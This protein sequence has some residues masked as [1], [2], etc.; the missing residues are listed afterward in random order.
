MLL[1]VPWYFWNESLWV[2][3][4]VN[5]NL[6]FCCT[7][8]AAF[9]VNS[10]A[11]LYGNELGRFYAFLSNLQQVFHVQCLFVE[12]GNK[13][14]DRNINPVESLPVALAAFGEGWHNYHHVFPWDYK[15]SEFGDYKFNISTG[16]IDFFAK[17]GWA[18]D[19]KLKKKIIFLSILQT[20]QN[21]VNFSVCRQIRFTRNGCSA[22]GQ[23]WRWNASIAATATPSSSSQRFRMGIRRS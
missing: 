11:H 13:P 12:L 16:F 23:I 17:L 2:S 14:Y 22:C 20:V 19:R 9:C 4:W 8:N 15:T 3:F 18:Y 10:V 6:R 1:Q 21:D 5:F 7:L